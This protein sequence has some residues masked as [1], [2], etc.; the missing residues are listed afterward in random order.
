MKPRICFCRNVKKWK[1]YYKNVFH[2]NMCTKH[3]SHREAVVYLELL[4]YSEI[5]DRSDVARNCVLNAYN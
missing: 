3:V 1:I 2:G 4:Y 5:I